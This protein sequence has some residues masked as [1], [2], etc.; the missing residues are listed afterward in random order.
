[1]TARGGAWKRRRVRA[2][3]PRGSLDERQGRESPAVEP[4]VSVA[5]I[6]RL[7]QTAGNQAVSRLLQ[8]QTAPGPLLQRMKVTPQNKAEVDRLKARYLG[9]NQGDYEGWNAL[10]ESADGIKELREGVDEVAPE[11]AQVSAIPFG[12]TDRVGGMD[13]TDAA[14]LAEHYGWEVATSPEWTC[15]DR[16]HTPKGRVYTDGDG[17]YWGADNTGHV[18]FGFKMWIGSPRDLTYMGNVR[19]HSPHAL[20]QRGAQRTEKKGSGKE[21]KKEKKGGGKKK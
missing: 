19:H 2:R 13:E 15:K 1:L 4:P 7:Q 12:D 6:M 3:Q 9:V 18:G 10:V 16:K 17:N 5:A 21:E 14:R 20:I 11:Q 8:T